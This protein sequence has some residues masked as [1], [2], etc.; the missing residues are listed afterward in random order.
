[1]AARPAVGRRFAALNK[2]QYH[3]SPETPT[4][5]GYRV[6]SELDRDRTDEE[7]RFFTFVQENPSGSFFVFF[8]TTHKLGQISLCLLCVS[9]IYAFFLL[10]RFFRKL[11]QVGGLNL[12]AQRRVAFAV[13]K[14][15]SLV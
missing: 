4:S 14:S 7:H 10:K 8:T 1:M 11:Y 3:R 5:L 9:S 12:I 6:T 15:Q 2:V 13:F